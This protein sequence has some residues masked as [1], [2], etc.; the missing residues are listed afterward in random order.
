MGA[1]RGATISGRARLTL[2]PRMAARPALVLA[3]TAMLALSACSSDG[4]TGIETPS[5]TRTP[6]ATPTSTPILGDPKVIVETAVTAC[7]QKDGELLAS[8]VSGSVSEA[9]LE[10]LFSRGSDVRLRSFTFPAEEGNIVSVTVGLVIQRKTGA[11]E[12]ERI[13]ELEQQGD[14]WR[15]TSLPDCF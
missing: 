6:A 2:R 7:R 11:E 12:V 1:N 4:T 9:D 3:I 8:L 15:F 14:I 10:A 13:W 5:A